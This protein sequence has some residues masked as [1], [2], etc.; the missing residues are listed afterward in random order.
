MLTITRLVKLR[1]LCGLTAVA[2]ALIACTATEARAQ[3]FFSPFLGYD[4][5]GNSICPNLTGCTQENLNFGFSFG[6][7]G[8]AVGFEEEIAWAKN[9]LGSTTNGADSSVL[10]VM[11]S[12]MVAPKI[13]PV[14]PYGLFGVGLM[15]ANVNLN[16]LNIVSFTNNTFAWDLGAGV[17]VFFGSHV[18]IRGDLRHFNSFQELNILGLTLGGGAK[19]NFGRVS[20]G[21]VLQ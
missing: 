20:A 10:T 8:N 3:G 9:F 12:F 1:Q 14:R 16:P 19:L 11:S 13:G 17:M 15:K 6:K 7:M 5:G 2:A 4:Y 18:G 21:V